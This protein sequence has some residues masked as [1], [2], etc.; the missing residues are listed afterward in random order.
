M[1]L[2]I[3]LTDNYKLISDS[4]N[5]IIARTEK[6]RV[7][8]EGFY[9]SIEGAIEGFISM[10]IKGFDSKTIEELIKAIKDLQ[11]ALNKALQPLNLEVITKEKGV[12]N[13]G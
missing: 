10:K 4:N 9:Q 5:I 11:T 7:F 1:S 8:H 6:D 12:E 3:P 2:D 13:N